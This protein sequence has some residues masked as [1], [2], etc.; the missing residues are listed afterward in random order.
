[1]DVAHQEYVPSYNGPANSFT[2][3]LR[4]LGFKNDYS[5]ELKR[6]NFVAAM[7]KHVDNSDHKFLKPADNEAAFSTMVNEFLVEHGRY[8]WGVHDRD[9]LEIEDISKG[10]LY[11]RDAHRPNSRS[12]TAQP[13]PPCGKFS[14][15]DYGFFPTLILIRP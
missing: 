10:Y 8:Y 12:V 13:Y 9:H 4:K 6:W 7:K 2:A 1:M 15:L 14:A 11:P 3:C 5:S